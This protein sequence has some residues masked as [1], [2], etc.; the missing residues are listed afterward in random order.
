MGEVFLCRDHRIGREVAMKV[1]R[2]SG[3][4]S[5]D[6]QARFL[7]EARVQ[8]QLEHPAIVPVYD[9][10]SDPEGRSFFTM[11]RVRG[12][13]LETIIGRLAAGDARAH[14]EHTRHKLL[15]AYARVCLALDFAHARGVVHRDLKPS[16]VMLGDFGEVY[17]LDW[18]IAKVERSTDATVERVLGDS[19]ERP[20]LDDGATEAGVILGTP[21]YMAPEQRRGRTV[22]ARTDVYALGA[23][24][25][26]L[27]TLVSLEECRAMSR[28][29]GRAIGSSREAPPESSREAADSLERDADVPP[30]LCAIWRKA[31]ARDPTERHRSARELHDAVE[32]F[33]SGD[34]DVATRRALVET[35][36]AAARELR[37]ATP[38]TREN[39]SRALL[40]V[41]R[42][43]ALDPSDGEAMRLLVELLSDPPTDTPPEVVVELERVHQ[44]SRRLALKRAVLMYTLP[45]FLFLPLIMLM[46][47]K[48]WPSTLLVLGSSLVAGAVAALSYF[49]NRITDRFPWV[50]IASSVA[51]ATSAVLSG[52]YVLLPTLVVGNTICHAVASRPRQ[53]RAVIGIGVLALLVPVA[54]ELFGVVPP[55]NVFEHGSL[56]ITSIAFHLRQPLTPI[57]L[58][59]ANVAFLVF[60]SRYLGKSRDDLTRAEIRHLSHLW[61]L[62]QLVPE[63]VRSAT[64]DPPPEPN[65][66]H[67][68]QFPRLG[69]HPTT[70]SRLI[71]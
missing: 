47:V 63:E 64:S 5:P 44:E 9:V 54:L 68:H 11:K 21:S 43:I 14:A 46:G 1:V 31:T 66:D 32:S 23:I 24:L 49:R 6:L 39:R 41:G 51:M 8:G 61:Q 45:S 17:V 29:V 42:A 38:E 33:L 15:A 71:A 65:G 62:R 58:V 25:F 20:I 27:L 34:R 52:A 13:T 67:R 56:V 50:A 18:G 26:E 19:G 59:I 7:R 53:R 36:V 48:S 60:T 57:F 69:S 30:E 2:R 40:E 16:N 55:C 37:A 10:G 22:D 3:R 35:H 4:A 28:A 70:C 12:E